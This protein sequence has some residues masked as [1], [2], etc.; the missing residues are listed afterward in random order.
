M[1]LLQKTFPGRVISRPGDIKWPPR[2]CDLSPF[3][4]FLWGYAIDRVYADKLSTLEY[5]KTN[6][7]QVM[8]KIPTSQYVLKNGRKLPKKNQCLQHF[9]RRSFK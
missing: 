9:A 2:S 1:A 3:D 7:R 5:L 8:T 4:S 6:I